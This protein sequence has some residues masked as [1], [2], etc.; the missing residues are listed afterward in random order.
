MKYCQSLPLHHVQ[1]T[2]HV[3]L[4]RW[5]A[6][7]CSLISD[8]GE[9]LVVHCPPDLRTMPLRWDAVDDHGSSVQL[10]KTMTSQC[11]PMLPMQNEQQQKPENFGELSEKILLVLSEVSLSPQST[12]YSSV[13]LQLWKHI[14]G[15]PRGSNTILTDPYNSGLTL[16]DS[17]TLV[18]EEDQIVP[19]FLRILLHSSLPRSTSVGQSTGMLQA[20]MG[21]SCWIINT[22]ERR[23]NLHDQNVVLLASV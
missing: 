21:L 2:R 6:S 22:D 1:W 11:S 7:G 4:L 20:S 13:R 17:W 23:R 8:S 18:H 12:D 14:Q 10:N 3:T 5:D 19:S 15:F 9:A 16:Q